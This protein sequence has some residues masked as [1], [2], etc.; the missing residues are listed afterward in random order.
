M[1]EPK[2][3]R[4]AAAQ[5]L[6]EHLSAV[7]FFVERFEIEVDSDADLQITPREGGLPVLVHLAD[8]S[9]VIIQAVLKLSFPVDLD[10]EA[11]TPD[12]QHHAATAHD[13]LLRVLNMANLLSDGPR[14]SARFFDGDVG[15]VYART[16]LATLSLEP[17]Y[18][19]ALIGAAI[20]RLFDSAMRDLAQLE[21]LMAD[22]ERLTPMPFT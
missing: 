1:S 22:E 14:Y 20:D 19:S 4:P 21:H 10:P 17:V 18:A 2:F 3:D 12:P 16:D 6:L 13:T 8:A 15:V 5:E 11:V 9:D 7:D